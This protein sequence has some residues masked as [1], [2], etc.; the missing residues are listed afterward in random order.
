M[1]AANFNA[2]T[3]LLLKMAVSTAL[4]DPFVMGLMHLFFVNDTTAIKYLQHGIINC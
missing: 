3:M 4:F 1:A 2:V